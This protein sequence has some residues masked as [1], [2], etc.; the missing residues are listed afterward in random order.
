M[1]KKILSN[2]TFWVLF[3]ITAGILLGHFYPSAGVAMQPLGKYFIEVIK[4]FIYPIILVTII[5]GICGMDSL[6][7]VGMVGGKAL[8]YFEVV[9][10]L[11]LL[12]GVIVAH[13]IQPGSGVDTAVVS[14]GDISK[15]NGNVS[16][17]WLQFLKD[18]ITIQVLLFSIIA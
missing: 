9:T 5:T 11:A 1:I 8:I 3:A 10:T 4:V 17:S 12:I 18:N 14:K 6:K 2:L 7:R 15:Y 16:I 13:F